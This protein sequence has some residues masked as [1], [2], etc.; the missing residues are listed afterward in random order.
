MLF[1]F[2][3]DSLQAMGGILDVRWAHNGIVTVGPYCTAQGIIQQVGELGVALITLILTIHT[4]VVAVWSVGSQARCFAFGMVGLA[5]L[6][7]ALWVGL[8]N[9][10]DKNFETP[11]PYWCWV[12]PK[13]NGARLAGEYIWLWIALF[14]SLILNIPLYIWAKG[15]LSVDLQRMLFYPLAYSIVVLPVSIT[16]WLTFSH[17]DM[18]VP[19]AATFFSVSLHDLSGAINVLLFFI[20]RPELLLFIPPKEFSEPEIAD[21]STSSAIL[22]ETVKYNHSPQPTGMELAGDGEWNPPHDANDVAL[23]HIEHRP[24]LEGLEGI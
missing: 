12:G 7:I 18:D 23:P 1:L 5:I 21:P 24:R 6:F 4:F 14:A 17:K 19:S 9:G 13:Y 20:I 8:G 11:T 15:R 2:V 3:F 16:R 10:L 22:E